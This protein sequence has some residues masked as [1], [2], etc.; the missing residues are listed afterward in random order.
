MDSVTRVPQYAGESSSSAFDLHRLISIFRRHLV[1]FTIVASVIVAASVVISLLA[2]PRYR[3]SSDIMLDTRQESVV[4][5]TAVLSKLPSTDTNAVDTEVEVLRSR[6]LAEKVV[7]ELKLDQVPE[8][9]VADTGAGFLGLGDLFSKAR[10]APA[11]TGSA[12]APAAGRARERVVDNVMERLSIRRAGLT[13]VINLGFESESPELAAKVANAFADQYLTDQLDAKFNANRQANQWLAK[14]VGEMAIEVQSAEAEVQQY[15]IANNLMSSQ[16]TTLVEQEISTLEQQRATAKTEQAEAEARLNI[17]RQQM[18]SG[19]TGED[20]GETLT[21]PV[22]QQLR[23]QRAALSARVADL[24]GRYGP[25]H[26]DMLKAQRELQDVDAQINAEIKRIIS[27]LDAQ[28]RVARQRT[29]SIVGTVGSAR[30]NLAA[31]NRAGVRLAELERKAQSVRTLYESYLNRYK[32]TSAQQG[33]EHSDARIVSAA[34]IPTAPSYP[35]KLLNVGLGFVL[36]IGAG[37][38]AIAL[39]EALNNGI[40]TAEDVERTFDIRSLGSIPELRSTLEGPIA[41]LSKTSPASYVVQNPMSAFAESFRSLRTAVLFSKPDNQVK[42]IAVTSSLPGEGKTT[43]SMCLARTA[44]M[45]GARVVVVDCDLRQ[46]SLRQYVTGET[47]GGLIEVLSGQ[48]PLSEALTHDAAS[49][50]YILANGSEA[51]AARDLFGGPVIERLLGELRTHFDL[52]ILDTAP[53]LP[54]AD[55][56]LLA[57]HADAVILL[58]RWRKTPRKAVEASLRLLAS[59]G[60]FIAGIALTKVDIRAQASHGYGDPGQYYRDYKSYYG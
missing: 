13:Y 40:G 47:K 8:F 59:S 51:G 34:K 15:K 38:A 21:S 24:Q 5:S 7:R 29:G 25:R 43:T 9:A 46:R 37:L 26:P 28:A 42:V 33:L 36:A 44:A 3:A 39:A 14:K 1:L 2:T 11:S 53:V 23:Q 19:S 41:K 4:D 54:I 55:T 16:G 35:K 31:N 27:N 52:V 17:A 32:E 56:R 20:V 60:G 10:P 22:V 48:V 30:G 49:G 45:G 58:T 6:T 18:A 12:A 50:A 57:H